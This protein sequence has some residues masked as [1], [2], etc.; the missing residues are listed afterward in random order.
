MDIKTLNEKLDNLLETY[1][2]SAI[3]QKL[4]LNKECG[5]SVGGSLTEYGQMLILYKPRKKEFVLKGRNARYSYQMPSH[6]REV[7]ST[8]D[9]ALNEWLK[10]YA[11]GSYL[12][13]VHDEL[14]VKAQNELISIIKQAGGTIDKDG[15]KIII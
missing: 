2:T 11:N 7:F 13:C 4:M 9:E 5:L 1:N 3:M 10:Y 8:L 6:V 14:S 15:R 12:F